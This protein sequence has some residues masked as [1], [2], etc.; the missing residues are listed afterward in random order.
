MGLGVRGVGMEFSTL[1]H[2]SYVGLFVC[3]SQP[4]FLKLENAGNT[5]MCTK[6]LLSSWHG[7]AIQS[8][9]AIFVNV[10]WGN[11]E[12]EKVTNRSKPL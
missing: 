4:Q 2:P 6:S 5:E 10:S 11:T 12:A 7:L 3:F 1:M 8:M 9:G